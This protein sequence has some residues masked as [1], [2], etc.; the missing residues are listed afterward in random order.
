MSI[1]Y[2]CIRQTL[3]AERR[4][5]IESQLFHPV[6]EMMTEKYAHDFGTIHNH[7]LWGVAAVGICGLVIGDERYLAMALDGLEGDRQ[8]GVFFAEISQLFAPSGYYVEGP[9]YHRFAI[10]P[11]L[12]FAEALQLHRPELDIYNYNDQTIRRTIKALLATTYP[13][14]CLPA[15]NDASRS[16][17]IG[18][19][20]MLIAAAVYDARYGD[21]AT[22]H[23]LA[24]QQ[25]QVW[26]QP[27]ALGLAAAADALGSDAPPLWPSIEL[28]EGPHGDRGAQ[29]FLRAKGAMATS[30]RCA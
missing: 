6:V 24:R 25:G 30:A 12:I 17:G 3:S 16:M 9:Y 7:G 10:R 23:A 20:G 19:E 29:G 1:G 4:E 26:V 15:L 22:I 21:D 11:L 28:S 13:N 5:H 14:G 27:A 8:S 2:G 18:D